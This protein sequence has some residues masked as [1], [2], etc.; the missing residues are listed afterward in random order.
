MST[1]ESTPDT[2]SETDS[3]PHVTTGTGRPRAIRS[4]AYVALQLDECCPNCGGDGSFLKYQTLFES[5]DHDYC[6]ACDY[7]RTYHTD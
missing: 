5:P 4:T 2:E 7:H 6:D 1:V 3:K